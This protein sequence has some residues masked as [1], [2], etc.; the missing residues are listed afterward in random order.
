MMFF[1]FLG[2]SLPSVKGSKL[3]LYSWYFVDG[4]TGVTAGSVIV[5]SF[6][7]ML[8]P[9]DISWSFLWNWAFRL[10]CLPFFINSPWFLLAFWITIWSFCMEEH[11]SIFVWETIQNW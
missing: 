2:Y 1:V 8:L 6:S 5:E 9:V 11:S 4:W 3:K 10:Q 7:S